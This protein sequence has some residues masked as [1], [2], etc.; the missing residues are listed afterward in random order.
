MTDIA[1]PPRMVRSNGVEAPVSPAARAQF[2][3]AHGWLRKGRPD[4]ALQHFYRALELDAN[5]EGAHVK[6]A[7]LLASERRWQDTIDAC[8]T[9]LGHFPEQAQLHK[10]LAT[11]I[12]ELRGHDAAL[13]R[14]GLRRVGD[15]PVEVDPGDVLGCLVVRNEAARLPWFLTEARRLGVSTFLVVDNG[16]TDGTVELLHDQP[17]VRLWET[18]MSFIAGN[19]GS[20]WFEVLLRRYGVGHWALMLDA[21][22]ILSF[23]GDEGTSLRELCSALDRAGKRAM[24]GVMIDMYGPGPVA[25]TR[26]VPGEDFLDHCQYFDRLTHH[27]SLKDAGPYTNQVFHF[28]GARTRVFGDDVDYLVTKTPL[29]RYD[30]EVVLAGGQ[31]WT[32]HPSEVIAHDA[33]AVLHFKY[34]ASLVD[35]A[36]REAERAEDSHWRKQIESYRTTFERERELCLFDPAESIAFEKSTQL[37]ELGIVNEAWRGGRPHPSVPVIARRAAGSSP[38]ATPT[39]SVMVTVYDRLHSVE[40]ALRSVLAQARPDMQIAVVADH[41][42]PETSAQLSDLLDSIPGVSDR[43]ELHQ[44]PIRVGHPQVFNECIDRARCDWVHI[45]HDDDW[46]HPGF[47]DALQE[48]IEQAP[49]IGAAF[50]RHELPSAP[51]R[52]WTSW[53]EQESAGVIDD[54]LDRIATEC[55]VQFSAMTVRRSTYEELGGFRTEI[56]SAFDWEMWQRIAARHPVW[57]D[58]SPL[59]VV[60]RDGTAETNRLSSDGGQIADL[61]SAIE[62][63]RRYLPLERVDLLTRR[64]RERCAL[65]GLDLAAAQLRAGLPAAANR[66]IAAALAASDTPRVV[67]ALRRLL[68]ETANSGGQPPP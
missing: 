58:P 62:H 12:G 14:Y 42:G 61:L 27:R 56:G 68:A 11:S 47:Y 16:S 40:R 19:Y 22:E 67:D 46:L 52:T 53:L 43:V 29:V 41:H 5:L 8:E 26:Y 34:F 31:H 3:L 17:D 51:D 6:L 57:F 59:A 13:A 38:R 35:R 32:S 44:L 65:H 54:W 36:T 2:G 60:Y 1:P 64:A 20:A 39:W 30:A 45:L 23:P 49:D 33:C 9:G 63:A 21:D 55:R 25:D 4:R 50:V 7:T 24:S 28:G 48:G 37:V 66:N 15:R 10:L 18:S